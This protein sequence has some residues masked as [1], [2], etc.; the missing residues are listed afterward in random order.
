[1]H[2]PATI[3]YTHNQDVLTATPDHARLRIELSHDDDLSRACCFLC[4][5]HDTPVTFTVHKPHDRTLVNEATEVLA[6][7]YWSRAR[8]AAG[9]Q[10]G[11]VQIIPSLDATIATP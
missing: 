8:L 4:W 6:A 9:G 10:P 2:T 11:V 5:E 3:V 7:V 1:M